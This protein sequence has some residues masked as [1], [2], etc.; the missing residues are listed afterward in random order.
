[1]VAID[2]P[3]VLTASLVLVHVLLSSSDMSNRE[4]IISEAIRRCEELMRYEWHEVGMP[5]L[6]RH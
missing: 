2:E 6:S 1:M 5:T 4:E 3:G